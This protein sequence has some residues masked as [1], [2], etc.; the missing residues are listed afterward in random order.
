MNDSRSLEIL[1]RSR[2]QWRM[3]MLT[4]QYLGSLSNDDGDGDD[5]DNDNAAK[6]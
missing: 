5:N 4:T 3:V 2:F 1:R 6:Q